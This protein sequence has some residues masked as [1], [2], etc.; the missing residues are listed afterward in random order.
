MSHGV[1]LSKQQSPKTNEE[2]KKMFVVPYA[3]AVGNI[4]YVAQCT[5]PN[6]AYALNVTSRYQACAGEAQWPAVKTLLKYLRSTKDM[7]LV[8][9]GGELILEDYS[10][11]SF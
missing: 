3:S 2:L 11:V 8:Y 6:V 9:D 5:R 1:K 7:F 10:N 4:Q